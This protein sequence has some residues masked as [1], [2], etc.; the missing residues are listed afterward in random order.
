MAEFL[1]QCMIFY[2]KQITFSYISTGFK[3]VSIIGC[4]FFT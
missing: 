2:N 4:M 1:T 3:H